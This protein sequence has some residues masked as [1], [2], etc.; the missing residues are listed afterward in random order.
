MSIPSVLTSLAVFAL[1][2][3]LA[4][5]VGSGDAQLLGLPALP[6]LAVLSFAIQWMA[7]IPAFAFQTEH[8]YDLTGSLSYLSLIML[9]FWSS[10]EQGT[11]GRA[12]VL[13]LVCS[14]WAIRLGSFLF[15]RVKRAG[16]DGRFD[17]IKPDFGRFLLAWTLQG[18]WVFLTLLAALIGMTRGGEGADLLLLVGFAVWLAGFAIE[19][20]ADV[21]KSGFSSQPENQGRFIDV[22]L[23]SRSRH[24]NYFGEIVLWI[25]VA[26][27]ATPVMS[28]WG[29]LGWLS[30]VFVAFLLMKV[31]GVPILERRADQKWGGQS[32]YEAYKDATP[33]LIPR[34]RS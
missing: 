28:H 23:W 3:I 30:P 5:V 2:L 32:D 20:I 29:W 19:A 26:V 1:G 31:S 25:G 14:I 7:F 10:L 33:V 22:G 34:L 4:I 16:K 17:D 24:P 9:G 13:A 27:M 12:V 21:Q 18:L 6:V 8:Y 11:G 15:R